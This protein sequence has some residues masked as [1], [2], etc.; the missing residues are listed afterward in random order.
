[1]G[2]Y[3]RERNRAYCQNV[4]YVVHNIDKYGRLPVWA[5]VEIMSFGTLSML[6][7]NLDMRAG[8]TGRSPGVAD[9]VAEAFGTKQC[10]LKLG[11]SSGHREKHCC[12]S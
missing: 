9:A 7:G 6:Y 10:Y 5:A 3:E 11:A 4:P 12:P 2:N 8:K 1:M